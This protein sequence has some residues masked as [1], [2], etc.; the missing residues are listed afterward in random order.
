MRTEKE[1]LAASKEF[2]GEN[3]LRSWYEFLVTLLLIA[4]LLTVCFFR[5]IPL[6]AR[7]AA[8]VIS[9]LLYVRLFVIYHDYRHRAILLNSPTASLLMKLVGLYVLAPENI[10]TRSHEHHHNNNSK[11]TLSG[12]G[13]Y[14]T[15]SKDRFLTLTPAQRRLYLVN[16]HPLTIIFGYLT[17]FIYW[18]N[19]K[20]FIESPKKHMDSL[21]ALVLHA[22]IGVAIWI[23]L[24]AE[25]YVLAWLLP[26]FIMSGLGAYLFYCQHNFPGA[27]FRPNQDWTYANAALSS[28]SYMVMSPVMHWFTANIGY[29]HVH[30]INSRIPFYR[31]KEAMNAM[32]ELQNPR[33]TSW[34][35]LEVWRC[36]RLKAWDNESGKMITM[37]QLKAR[38]VPVKA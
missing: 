4:A 18:L 26:I 28:T 22:G 20:S 8:S 33:T 32:P 24:G 10:W 6:A 16:R 25:T 35:L 37:R 5:E 12:I 29:H 17:L 38:P 19:L 27:T 36:F 30:H 11:L 14:P 9:G 15:V 2:V 31:L 34:N 23:Q 1:I 21:L 7:L 3:R 13:S